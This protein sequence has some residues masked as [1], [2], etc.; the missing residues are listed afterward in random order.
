[1]TMIN[2]KEIEALLDVKADNVIC[3]KFCLFPSE[4]AL[5]IDTV[6]RSRDEY[7]Y[8]LIGAESTN[9]GYSICGIN[10]T[11]NFTGILE[12][13][14]KQLDIKL[15]IEQQLCNFDNKK[16]W[17]IKVKTYESLDINSDVKNETMNNILRDLYLAC[18]KLQGNSFYYDA[19]EDQRNDFVR[20]IMETT[21]HQ[22]KD[23]T[24]R[25]LSAAGKAAGELD[26]F[27]HASGFPI[28]I[29]EALNLS[30]LD[31]AYLDK[32]IDKVYN[33]DTA[34]NYFNIILSY[35][36]VSNFQDF[37]SK[38][39]KHIKEHT[40]PFLMIEIDE[41]CCISDNEYSDI[42]IMMTKHNRNG[43]DTFL[44]HI[45]VRIGNMS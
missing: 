33:Y 38:Y 32:H 45:C 29:I 42:K 26:I 21:G 37:C 28:T 11:V 25:G 4:I 23:Q 15:D 18:I 31:R 5:Y 16:I 7:G 14:K 9:D 19:T 17:V 22:V 1:M 13:A 35:V 12:N 41:N 2:V 40:Y 36:K 10:T 39:L 44:Y 20:D 43:K 24:R 3:K 27:I 8:I 6:A 34:G 30:S